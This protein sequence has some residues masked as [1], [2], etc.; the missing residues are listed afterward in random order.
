MGRDKVRRQPVQMVNSG[1]IN[2]LYFEK[3]FDVMEA[4]HPDLPPRHDS[5]G[6]TLILSAFRSFPTLYEIIILEGVIYGWF[7]FR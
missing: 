2:L 7:A 5:S 6:G 4:A 3:R 1:E